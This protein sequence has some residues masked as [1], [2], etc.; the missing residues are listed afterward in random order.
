VRTAATDEYARFQRLQ[1]EAETAIQAAKR[2]LEDVNKAIAAA[3]ERETKATESATAAEAR[4]A[5]AEEKATVT[6]AKV[7]TLQDTHR[8]LV[9][10]LTAVVNA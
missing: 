2:E 7:R 8:D 6:E 10:K 4:S 3:R 9:G 1:G 5:V